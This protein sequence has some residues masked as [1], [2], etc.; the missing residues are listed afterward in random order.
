MLASRLL[1]SMVIGLGVCVLF[2]WW[3]D[4][5]AIRTVL[6]G[7]ASMKVNTATCF[8]LSG[9]ALFALSLERPRFSLA[10][11]ALGA[12]VLLLSAATVSQDLFNWNLGLDNMLFDV[13][14]IPAETSARMAPVTALCFALCGAALAAGSRFSRASGR[15]ALLAGS[16]ALL[17]FFGYLLD[18]QAQYYLAIR[19]SMAVHTAIGFL[20]LSAGIVLTR[21]QQ[22]ALIQWIRLATAIALAAQMAL[23][24]IIIDRLHNLSMDDRWQDHPRQVLLALEQSMGALLDAESAQR[25]YLV[26]GDARHQQRYQQALGQLKQGLLMT[27]ART[28]DNPSQKQRLA[29]AE[30]IIQDKLAHMADDI[31]AMVRIQHQQYSPGTVRARMAAALD[32]HY[33]ARIRSQF[34]LIEAEERRLLDARLANKLIE[35]RRIVQ[36][37]AISATFA[38]LTI[39]SVFLLLWR[40]IARR[41]SA[42]AALALQ[43][44]QLEAQV[45]QRTAHLATR[46]QDLRLAV[47][48]ANLGTWSHVIGTDVV[49]ASARCLEMFGFASDAVL[50][51]AQFMQRIHPDDLAK[52]QKDLHQATDTRQEFHNEYRVLWPDGSVHWIAGAALINPEASDA[53]QPPERHIGGVVMDQTERRSNEE[54]L[55]ASEAKFSLLFNQGALPVVLTRCSDRM[56]V[57]VNDAWLDLFGYTKAELIGKSVPP[58]SMA[59]GAPQAKERPNCVR[60]LEQTLFSKNGDALT[61]LTSINPVTIAGQDFAL[62]SHYD[63]TERRKVDLELQRHRDHMEALVQERTLDLEAARQRVEKFILRVPIAICVLEN[64]RISLRNAEFV[65][66]FGYTEQDIP[67]I[68]A[69]WLRACPD[70][71]YRAGVQ[72]N[73]AEAVTL[74]KTQ[75]RATPPFEHAVTCRDGSVRHVEVSGIAL[76]QAFLATFYDLTERRRI[77]ASMVERE[78]FLYTITDAV[79]GMVGYWSADLRCRFANI[80]YQEWF[81]VRPQELVGTYLQ[82]MMG[83]AFFLENE[84]HI[85]AALRGE[86]QQFERSMCKANGEP[87]YQWVHYIPD[88][89]DGEVKGFFVQISDV[90][91]LK[92]TQVELERANLDLTN[93]TLD[94]ETANRAK[95]DFLATMS[96]E[97]RTPMNAIL[98]SAQVLERAELEPDQRQLVG[99]ISSAGRGLLAIL[100]D[101]LDFAKIE[102]GQFT[103]ERAPFALSSVMHN[104]VDIFSSSAANQGL[105]LVLA[106]LPA[107]VGTLLGDAHRL[108]QVLHNLTGNAIKFTVRGSVTISITVLEQHRASF[109]LRFGV[110]DTGIGI[111]PEQIE[112]LFA[113]F[114]QADASTCRQYGGTGL[115]LAICRQL[116]T[117]MDGQIGAASAPGSGSEFWFTLPFDAAQEALAAAPPTRHRAG[118]RLAGLHLLVVD[119]SDLNLTIARNLLALEGATCDLA[120][121]G[122]A[123]L[124]RLRCGPD[125]IDCVLM[126]VQMP[127]MDG[128]SA[129]QAMRS[130]LGLANLP[131]IAL[132]AGVLPSQRERAFGA[133][134]NDFIA[135]PFELDTMVDAILRHVSARLTCAPEPE[136][137]FETEVEAET[138]YGDSFPPVPGIDGASAA[139]RLL[140]NQALFL[141]ALRALRDEFRAVAAH[142][143]ADFARGD[144]LSAARRLHKLRGVAGNVG[145]EQIAMLAGTLEVMLRSEPPALQRSELDA[146]DGALVLLV[147]GLPTDIDQRGVIAPSGGDLLLRSADLA[148]IADVEKLIA[149]LEDGDME[150]CKRFQALRPALGDRHGEAELARLSDAMDLL[151]FDEVRACLLDRHR[152]APAKN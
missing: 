135:K 8:A 55:R 1:A 51:L 106:P 88:Q 144:V 126:D 47:L 85:R 16:L 7:L 56:L 132:S 52:L 117:L 87:G 119:D 10:S 142:T 31:S 77:E 100:N 63:I 21:S 43:R 2:G 39:L 97:I 4:I 128:L 46:E 141:A 120:S 110:R 136:A 54:A 76:D 152:P 59:P 30:L 99:A 130:E 94:A 139:R 14:R 62:I 107:G 17:A 68:D 83:E 122:Q 60:N 44:D 134:M 108:G 114:V 3:R 35:S 118:I 82:D 138:G 127:V 102:A 65:H 101:V 11:R 13:R 27:R 25:G 149:L 23:G 42:E 131:I 45:V 36:T 116:V 123:A 38:T 53:L 147:A 37:L 79:P 93:R 9:L 28:A 22:S 140:G 71:L 15:A 12:L 151:R 75:N 95:S 33:L 112:R 61:V 5:P 40:A 150:A 58:L 73:W 48:S 66:L 84:P 129:A 78:H 50:T 92:R 103:L 41:Q 113:P 121:D 98:G 70:P 111:A 133:G 143:E 29:D 125:D 137:E 26:T 86:R 81:G 105:A 74:A 90:T 34:A 57:D 148:D 96:H 32:Q 64:S 20:I 124:D 115:G 69:W 19:S 91:T 89:A 67:T 109:T 80:G 24:L 146:L 6:P 18:V 72:R 49:D 145:A 104:L